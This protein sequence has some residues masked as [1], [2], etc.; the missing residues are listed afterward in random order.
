[1]D[2]L[3]VEGNCGLLYTY[4]IVAHRKMNG[5]LFSNRSLDKASMAW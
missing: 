3:T 1:M 2:L 4:R 5:D